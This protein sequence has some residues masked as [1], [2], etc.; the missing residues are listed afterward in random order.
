M[1]NDLTEYLINPVVQVS[2]VS[3]SSQKVYILGEVKSQ[4]VFSINAPMKVI[5]VISLAG[6]FSFGAKTENVF[7]Y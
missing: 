5:E 2:I 4:G 6:G 7:C 1:E 3:I